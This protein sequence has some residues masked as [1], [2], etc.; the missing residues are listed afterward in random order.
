MIFQYNLVCW[1]II[2]FIFIRNKM[3]LDKEK[4]D[5]NDRMLYCMIYSI[6]FDCVKNYEKR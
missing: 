1:N 6:A 4:I 5:K 2:V 3:T